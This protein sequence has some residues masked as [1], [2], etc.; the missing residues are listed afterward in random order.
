MME[1]LLHP[2]VW[3]SD[4]L[5]QRTKPWLCLGSWPALGWSKPCAWEVLLGRGGEMMAMNTGAG[6][7]TSTLSQHARRAGRLF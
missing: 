7:D 4:A 6:E 5:V 1:E 3:T 2:E